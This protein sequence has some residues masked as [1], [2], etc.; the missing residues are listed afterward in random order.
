[1]TESQNPAK[2]RVRFPPSPTGRLHLGNLRTA[3]FNWLFARHSSG[4]FVFRIEDT[5]KERSKKEFEE[6]IIEA[7]NWLG[8]NW[9]EGIGKERPGMSYRQSERTDIYHSHLERLLREGQAYWCYCAKEE[10]EAE[11]ALAAAE[12]RPV[13]YSGKC[14]NLSGSPDGKT[15]QVIRLKVDPQTIVFT[16]LIRGEVKFDTALLDDFVVAKNLD[17]PLYNFA[18]V[19]D[20]EDM[21]ITHVIRGEEHISN[22]PR[23]ILILNALKKPMPLYA[24]LPLILNAQRA[25]L[26]K[27]EADVAVLDYR[28]KGY[29]PEAVI[30][31]LVLM[32]WHPSHDKEVFTLSELI[33]EFDLLRVQKAGAVF[34]EE[35]LNWLN[36]EH[37]KKLSLSEL[38][39]KLAP[40]FSNKIKAGDTELRMAALALVRDRMVTLKDFNDLVEFF[41]VLPDYSA[42]L[43]IWKKGSREETR[44]VLADILTALNS[45]NELTREALENDLLQLID[46][47]GKGVIKIENQNSGML[48]IGWL[49]DKLND[50]EVAAYLEKAGVKSIALSLYTQKHKHK[51]AL[52]LGYT[53]FNEKKIKEYTLLMIEVIKKFMSSKKIVI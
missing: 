14:R 16:D 18:V 4:D 3:L 52:I 15:P 39:Q 13:K 45:S 30:N 6:S 34:N 1:M 26:S 49:H 33:A 51:P 11:K 50:Q 53:A 44:E 46:K 31:F 21:R 7:M 41:F 2:I 22:T 24:H 42:D 19:V 38:D 8:L 35:K 29:L 12:G 32:G 28:D 20:D 43:L 25:K 10:L 23:Q 47:Y 36:K 37:M 27:R 5:D 48:V 9:D 17:E 40:F